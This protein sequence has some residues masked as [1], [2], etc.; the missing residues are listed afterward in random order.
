MLEAVAEQAS[1]S[2]VVQPSAAA[3]LEIYKKDLREAADLAPPLRLMVSA[4][5][6]SF[7]P[8]APRKPTS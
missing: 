2:V 4:P 6:H 5:R 1:A 7:D 8:S 3:S